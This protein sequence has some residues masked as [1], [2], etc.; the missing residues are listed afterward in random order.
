MINHKFSSKWTVD[1]EATCAKVG[2]KSHH[3]NVCGE[4]GDVTEIP[5]IDHEF[6]TEW[7]VDKEATCTQSGLKSHHCINCDAKTD[8]TKVE[9][10]G[11]KYSGWKVAKK[12][13]CV[14]DG[15]LVKTC[16]SCGKQE[17][18]ILT[19]T[20][21]HK[22]ITVTTTK[23]TTSKNGTKTTKCSTCGKVKSTSKI[24]KIK[25]VKLSNTTYT[26]NG[27]AKK[28]TVTVKDSNGNKLK[29]GTDYTVK[30]SSGR[31]NVGKYTVTVTFKGRYSG[32]KK[33]TYKINPKSTS[34]YK[35]TAG[36]KKF[37]AKWYTRS[38][39]ASGYQLQY[40]RY[41]SMKN[42]STKTYSGVSKNSR[43]V[44]NLKA[45]TKYYVRVRTYKNVKISGNTYK[46]YSSWSSI[47]SV[48]T[49]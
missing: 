47:K 22:Y 39:Q 42:A 8:V 6:S 31:K 13:T 5:M 16:S 9:A 25:S 19:A 35:L 11:H 2:S 4:M 46:Y 37:T 32:T 15:E 28:P 41:S 48:K 24:Y 10:T 26:Y 21:E 14:K 12:A 29:E 44:S 34:I 20:G 38:E 7:T 43:T 17:T 36:K 40:S 30:Y 33:L 49:K 27:N 45:K 3:C 1:V 23:A 18:S